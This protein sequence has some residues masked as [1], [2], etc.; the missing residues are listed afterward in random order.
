MPEPSDQQANQRRSQPGFESMAQSIHGSYL[1]RWTRHDPRAVEAAQPDADTR[2]RKG[3]ARI[4]A[5]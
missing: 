2:T 1:R 4:S 3:A 5:A